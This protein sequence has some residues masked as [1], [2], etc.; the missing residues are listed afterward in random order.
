[1]KIWDRDNGMVKKPFYFDDNNEHS[2]TATE[3]AVADFA[4]MGMAVGT[5]FD[6]TGSI[7]VGHDSG[8]CAKALAESFIS[9]LLSTGVKVFNLGECTPQQIMYATSKLNSSAGCYV[10]S[11]YKA[12]IQI[13]GKGGLPLKRAIECR[14]ENAYTSNYFRTLDSNDYAKAY[15]FS[16]TKA[17][18]GIHL[19]K[20]LPDELHGILVNIRCT[21]RQTAKIADRLFHERN[22]IDGERIVFSI[23]S[24]GTT[25]SAYSEKTGYVFHERLIMLAMKALYES[26][27][28]VSL[29]YTVPSCAEDL[30]KNYGSQVFRYYSSSDDSG[31]EMARLVAQR[32]DNL[33][34]RDALG[35][36]CVIL[37]YLSSSNQTFP[38][39]VD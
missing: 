21:S 10:S 38:Q 17:L 20:M 33:F 29:P 36:I 3:A 13:K 8:N 28:E 34:V 14:I 31:D 27:H 4:K 32:A 1:M 16:D 2:F 39:A 9:G 11:T 37:G 22:D 23:S 15:D 25:C 5:A 19:E 7:V 35:L 24:D 26:G 6:I 18:Y 12:K 30:A